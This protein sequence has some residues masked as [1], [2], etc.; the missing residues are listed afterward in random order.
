MLYKKTKKVAFVDYL[1]NKFELILKTNISKWVK[2][3]Q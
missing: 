3:L 1:L 2:M